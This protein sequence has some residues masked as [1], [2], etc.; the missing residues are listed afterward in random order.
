MS[1][2]CYDAAQTQKLVSVGV[3]PG[4]V[5]MEVYF[6][7]ILRGVSFEDLLAGEV[8]YLLWFKFFGDMLIWGGPRSGG[9]HFGPPGGSYRDDAVGSVGFVPKEWVTAQATTSRFSVF[10]GSGSSLM[11]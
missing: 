10:L 7:E 3:P 8:L 11:L 5:D 4:A 1:T 2:V 6:A 9:P